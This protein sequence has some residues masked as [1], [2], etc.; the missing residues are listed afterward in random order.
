MIKELRTDVQSTSKTDENNDNDSRYT[1][2]NKLIFFLRI[3]PSLSGQ[4]PLLLH[5]VTTILP[6][7]NLSLFLARR[8]S[9]IRSHHLIFFLSWG[10][11][12]VLCYLVSTCDDLVFHLH[13]RPV[14]FFFFKSLVT[15]FSS[16]ISF[17]SML[18]FITLQRS[19]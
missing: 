12:V 3:F 8:F 15:L 13:T 14:V 11:G 7:A 5:F 4:S 10:G 16:I 1:T 2:H 17:N 6:L 18:V 9:L 19:F